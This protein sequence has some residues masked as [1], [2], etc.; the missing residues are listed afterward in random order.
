MTAEHTRKI[1]YAMHSF[2]IFNAFRG[3]SNTQF[4]SKVVLF[5]ALIFIKLQYGLESVC[6]DQRK[7]KRFD[8]FHYKCFRWIMKIQHSFFNCISNMQVLAAAG[9]KHLSF[10]MIKQQLK[11][12]GPIVTLNDTLRFVLGTFWMHFSVWVF[13]FQLYFESWRSSIQIISAGDIWY[14]SSV[15]LNK[16][17][18]LT[19]S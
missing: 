12:F 4:R 5:K 2:Q 9:E 7:R 13:M 18:V 15:S 3:H 14:K 1:G 16:W 19:M 10:T 11:S 8:A 6:F 17:T